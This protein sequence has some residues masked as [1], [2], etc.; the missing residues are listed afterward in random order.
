MMI[1]YTFTALGD[2]EGKITEIVHSGN[3]DAQSAL[4]IL[5]Q[6]VIAEAVKRANAEKPKNEGENKTDV[7]SATPEV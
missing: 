7:K 5:Q 6:I 2:D 3:I 1:T 4:N